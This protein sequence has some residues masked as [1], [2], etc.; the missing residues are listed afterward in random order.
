MMKRKASTTKLEEGKTNKK[1][2][3]SLEEIIT[4]VTMVEI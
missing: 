2:K 3:S 4:A 1:F